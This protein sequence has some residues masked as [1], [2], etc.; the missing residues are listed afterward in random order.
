MR[1]ECSETAR[2][3][4]TTFSLAAFLSKCQLQLRHLLSSLFDLES[5]H[6][7][8]GLAVMNQL[9]LTHVITD[10]VVD[11]QWTVSESST[12]LHSESRQARLN[13]LTYLSTVDPN[14][15]KLPSDHVLPPDRADSLELS[16]VQFA[17]QSTDCDNY[18]HRTYL[19]ALAPVP[20]SADPN[21]FLPDIKL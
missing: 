2:R 10:A 6:F 12:P 19:G 3:S 11:R 17:Y 5:H 20:L 8:L 15:P 14:D 1:N 21:F 4:Y 9:F 13:F 18:Q 16:A 7:H